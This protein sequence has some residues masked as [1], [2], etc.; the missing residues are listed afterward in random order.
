MLIIRFQRVGRKND[1]SFRLIVTDSRKSPKTGSYLELL[2]SYNPKTKAAILDK[3]RILAWKK[4]GAQIS[5]TVRNL[6]IS[7][8]IIEG[9]KVNVL[10]KKNPPKKEE[11]A[12]EVVQA[13]VAAQPQEATVSESVEPSPQVS[14]EATTEKPVA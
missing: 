7:K 5:D 9:K 14:E 3:E 6:L 13:S 1:P 11:A 8:G 2:G 12:A 4:D 10:P